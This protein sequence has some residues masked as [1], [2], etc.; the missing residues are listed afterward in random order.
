MH[1]DLAGNDNHTLWVWPL[2]RLIPNTLSLLAPVAQVLLKY[3]TN[4]NM[5]EA[6]THHQFIMYVSSDKIPREAG[7][8]MVRGRGGIEAVNLA[9]LETG[10]EASTAY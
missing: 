5:P 7:S 1:A 4:N 8:P 2:K 10:S 6:A 9:I 3:S